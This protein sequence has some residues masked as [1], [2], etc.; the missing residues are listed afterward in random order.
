MPLYQTG[1]LLDAKDVSKTD[2]TTKIK[3]RNGNTTNPF[4]VEVKHS[5]ETKEYLLKLDS[6]T[7][8][9]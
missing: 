5:D 3:L 2:K 6:E 8:D 7:P 4:R 9:G 1:V